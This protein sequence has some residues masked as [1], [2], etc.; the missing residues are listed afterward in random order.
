M[1]IVI[2]ARSALHRVFAKHHRLDC[3]STTLWILEKQYSHAI[4]ATI[5]QYEMPDTEESA[6][7]GR[8]REA[9]SWVVEKRAAANA[10]SRRRIAFPLS[11]RRPSSFS[12][13]ERRGERGLVGDRRRQGSTLGV[14]LSRKWE[15]RC[16]TPGWRDE[17]EGWRSGRR[18]RSSIAPP[19]NPPVSRSDTRACAPVPRHCVSLCT[20]RSLFSPTRCHRRTSRAW[21]Y[22]NFQPVCRS[23]R[24]VF[25]FTKTSECIVLSV[26]LR[27]L[28]SIFI[29]DPETSIASRK[30]RRCR[31]LLEGYFNFKF[32]CILILE[33]DS[34][35]CACIG[36]SAHETYYGIISTV[37]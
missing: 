17:G 7:S 22:S 12:L 32:P 35:L 14:S 34:P 25:T 36:I 20:S 23:A 31:S 19:G 16:E 3:I 15:S 24:S 28:Y 4:P 13:S 37:R 8:T 1:V 11:C 18:R 6:L 21:I 2:C 10:A 33:R 30:P 5:R 27:K 29:P 9:T 26:S